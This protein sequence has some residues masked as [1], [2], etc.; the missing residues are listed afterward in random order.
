MKNF[1]LALVALATLAG[2]AVALTSSQEPHL[3]VLDNGPIGVHKGD[4]LEAI[5]I[6]LDVVGWASAGQDA[7]LL[8]KDGVWVGRTIRINVSMRESVLVD[9]TH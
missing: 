8:V 4:R 2:V 6:T 3:P 1:A 5:G 9:C 7:W